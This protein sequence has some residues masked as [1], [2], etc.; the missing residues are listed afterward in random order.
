MASAFPHQTSVETTL[1]KQTDIVVS[2]DG[3]STDVLCALS[4][5]TSQGI[6]AALKK[7]PGTASDIADQVGT[8]LQNIHY[9]LDKLCETGL[10]EPVDTW[11]SA[12]GKE[13]TVYALTTEQLVIHFGENNELTA[14]QP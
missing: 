2:I 6:L 8:S 4:S 14:Q 3:E 7:D 5:E 10:I 9:H 11:Y 1:R 13:M 12:K